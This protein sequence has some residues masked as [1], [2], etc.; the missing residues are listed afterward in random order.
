[1]STGVLETVEGDHDDLAPLLPEQ[2]WCTDCAPDDT[3]EEGVPKDIVRRSVEKYHV[4]QGWDTNWGS[5]PEFEVIY[6]ACG[7]TQAHSI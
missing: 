1:M 3:S 5:P 6:L 7:H 4:G 2:E